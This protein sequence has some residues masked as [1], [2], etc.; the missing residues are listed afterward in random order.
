MPERPFQV[1]GDIHGRADLFAN[2]IERLD[3]SLPTI[4]V[5]DFIDRGDNSREILEFLSREA[6]FTCLMGNH[7]FMLLNF[8]SNPRKTGRQWLRH[9]GLQTLASFGVDGVS[10]T[11]ES[12]ALETARDRLIARMGQDTIAWLVDLPLYYM[13]GNV[14]VVHAGAD[15]DI[16]MD[17]Q[18]PRHLLWGHPKFLRKSRVDGVTVVFGHFIMDRPSFTDGRIA[19]DTGAYASGR[20]TAVRIGFGEATF[21]STGTT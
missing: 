4:I 11:S 17:G 21:I 13:S 2:L 6:N 14:A 18:A 7:E 1:I 9:G 3:G 10:E 20:L 8:L 16:P 12:E 5:G 19:V 15:P